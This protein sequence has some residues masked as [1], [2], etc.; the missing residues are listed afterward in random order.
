MMAD[1]STGLIA[2]KPAPTG[3]PLD[4]GLVRNLW[5]PAGRR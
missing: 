1:R 3:T 4:L 5:A 2:G